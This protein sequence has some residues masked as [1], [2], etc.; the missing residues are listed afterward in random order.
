MA[1]LSKLVSTVLFIGY[2]PVMPGTWGS[3]AGLGVFLL[4]KGDPLLTGLWFAVALALGFSF[5][6][7]A[8]RAFGKSDPGVVVIDEVAGMLLS[9]LC[10][11]YD[12]KLALIGFL[13]FRIFDTLKPFPAGRL[14]DLHGAAGI[15][16]DDVAAALYTN[17]LLQIIFRFI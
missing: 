10:V 8:E 2:L 15:M 6:G 12:L 16:L 11:P 1:F 13:L 9:L 7:A 17:F 14:Q 3:L 5:T 4:V